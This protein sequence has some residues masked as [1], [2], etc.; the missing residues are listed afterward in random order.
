MSVRSAGCIFISSSQSGGERG[1]NGGA[2]ETRHERKLIPDL[3]KDDTAKVEVTT[4]FTLAV[5]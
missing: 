4:M 1:T 3:F 5:N 2:G